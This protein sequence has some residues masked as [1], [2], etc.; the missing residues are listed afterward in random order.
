MRIARIPRETLLPALLIALALSS[1]SAHQELR[2]NNAP[3]RY[4]LVEDVLWASPAGFDLTMDIYTP[5][6]APPPDSHVQPAL[7]IPENAA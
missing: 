2:Q 7:S 1:C 5:G 6:H 4:T 3:D